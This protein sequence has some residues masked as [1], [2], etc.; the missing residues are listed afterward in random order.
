MDRNILKITLHN[1]LVALY[2]LI[3]IVVLFTIILV[4]FNFER[5]AVFIFSILFII[6]AIPG[7]YL[8]IE[9]WL[10]NKREE[11][12][13]HS[14][15]LIRYKNGKEE[16]YNAED[17]EQIKILMSPSLYQN[18]YLH[19]LAIEQYHFARVYL[20]NGE[21]LIITCL[22]ATRVDK[23]LSGLK[24]VKIEKKKWLFNSIYIPESWY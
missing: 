4:Y 9:Y 1:H 15:R 6:Q 5:N 13:I 12:G 21:K 20:K 17:I 8:H 14:D 18:W 10:C 23:A 7:L 2:F 19:F 24:G 22:L 16:Q 11:Y 3:V